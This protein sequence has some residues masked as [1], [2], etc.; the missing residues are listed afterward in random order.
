MGVTARRSRNPSRIFTRSDR[1]VQDLW[2]EWMP[3]VLWRQYNVS[4]LLGS[5]Q[6]QVQEQRGAWG[7]KTSSGWALQLG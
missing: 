4:G 2:R 6:R 3:A 5:P 7:Q 1:Q